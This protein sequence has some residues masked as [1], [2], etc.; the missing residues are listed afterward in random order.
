MRLPQP[1]VRPSGRP[2]SQEHD[3]RPKGLD[4]DETQLRN[5]CRVCEQPSAPP[6][7]YRVHEQPV[8]IHQVGGDEIPDQHDA[9]GSHDVSARFGL[10]LPNLVDEC[11]SQH[12]GVLPVGV[13]ERAGDDVLRYFVEVVGYAVVSSVCCGQ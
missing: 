5:L 10:Q 3:A 4:F 2:V 1:A 9:A 12:D 8:L 6:E 11:T 7:H 13:L